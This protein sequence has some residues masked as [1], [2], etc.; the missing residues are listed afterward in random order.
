MEVE[1]LK[2]GILWWLGVPVSVLVILWLVG[3]F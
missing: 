2:A 1:M 3:A